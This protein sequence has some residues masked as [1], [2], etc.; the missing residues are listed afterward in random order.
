[1]FACVFLDIRF[2]NMWQ[3]KEIWPIWGDVGSNNANNHIDDIGFELKRCIKLKRKLSIQLFMSLN[4]CAFYS[5]IPFSVL[6]ILN[7]IECTNEKIKCINR[8]NKSL[9][10]KKKNEEQTNEQ[11]AA[12]ANMMVS[13]LSS[14][15]GWNETI[16]ERS[17]WSMFTDSQYWQQWNQ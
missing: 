3:K 6:N 12:F 17:G 15:D 11:A 5:K 9:K 4:T 8:A 13:D 16:S 10:K 7:H 14:N 2:W 1:M